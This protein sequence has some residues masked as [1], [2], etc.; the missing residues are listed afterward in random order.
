MI[1]LMSTVFGTI[2]VKKKHF[3]RYYRTK[4]IIFI[5]FIILKR[6]TAFINTR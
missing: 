5:L 1:E 2:D 3:I 6:L 4:N